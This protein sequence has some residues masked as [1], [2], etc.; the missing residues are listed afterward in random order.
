MIEE[1]LLLALFLPLM[2][3]SLLV[4]AD[5][6]SRSV[7]KLPVSRWFKLFIIGILTFT[8]LYFVLSFSMNLVGFICYQYSIALVFNHF[9]FREKGGIMILATPFI[10][11]FYLL[12]VGF[13]DSKNVVYLPLVGF[14][15]FFVNFLLSKLKQLTS[16]H[17]FLIVY[18]STMLLAPHTA[19]QVYHTKNYGITEFF[20][21]LLGSIVLL[22]TFFWV[23]RL[24]QKEEYIVLEKLANSKV[25][26]L[27][28]SYNYATLNDDLIHKAADSAE[29]EI[30]IAMLD[31]DHFKKLNDH[32]GHLAANNLLKEFT[33]LSKDWLGKTFDCPHRF[34]RYGGEEFCIIIEGTTV[35]EVLN[36]LDNLRLLVK[37]HHFS[38]ANYRVGDMSLSCGVESSLNCSSDVFQTLKHADEALYQ[39]KENGRNRLYYY[40]D[41]AEFSQD[42]LQETS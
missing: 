22:G 39:A 8:H 25:D 27:T 2:I 5:V 13:P 38:I 16:D 4:T 29:G 15:V 10:V 34:Y 33:G 6:F 19:M 20:Y 23:H 37:K 36:G 30:I 24:I 9:F 1:G 26:A 42:N 21:V 3:A 28:G 12:F 17:R 18:F 31:L 35:S 40:P 7:Q 11:S 32:Y 41:T 14:I